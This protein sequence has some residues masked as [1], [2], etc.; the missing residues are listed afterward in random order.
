MRLLLPIL[1]IILVS[2]V[3]STG[4]E[5]SGFSLIEPSNDGWFNPEFSGWAGFSLTSGGGRTLGSGTY[6]GSMAF[7]LHPSLTASVDLGY[8]RL[9]DFHGLSSGRILGA[10]DLQWEAS[11]NFIFHL[12]CS[13]SLP[14]SSLTGF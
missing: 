4:L 7:S 8:T 3:L 1:L 13:G 12:H 6:V 9:Y 11:D 14:D 5:P 2:S 10:V